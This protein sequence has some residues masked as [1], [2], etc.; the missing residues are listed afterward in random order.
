MDE[1]LYALS[2]EERKMSPGLLDEY[3]RQF[4]EYADALTELAVD[5]AIEELCPEESAETDVAPQKNPLEVPAVARAMSR[6]QYQF[7][8]VRLKASLAKPQAPAKPV[9]N[10]FSSLTKEQIAATTT[11]LKINIP[12]FIKLRDRL[13]EVT[14]IPDA[15]IELVSKLLNVRVEVL[16]AHFSARPQLAAASYKATEK[17]AAGAQQSYKDAVL[18]S[19]LTADQQKALLALTS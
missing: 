2:M 14:T 4:P 12:F 3:V 10:P 15:F 11:K 8:A 1:V 19:G 5:L 16:R 6:F 9:E 7:N 18:N 13:I 17:P